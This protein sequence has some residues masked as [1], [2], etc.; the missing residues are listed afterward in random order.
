MFSETVCTFQ[1]S[2]LT[3]YSAGG[4]QFGMPFSVSN[5][6]L[7]YNKDAFTKA[8]LDPN[9]PPKTWSSMNT[10]SSTDGSKRA[11]RSEPA[12]EPLDDGAIAGYLPVSGQ[13]ITH[14]TVRE[15]RDIEEDAADYDLYP[16]VSFGVSYRF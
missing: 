5:P 12:D 15:E 7:Y 8:G 10:S 2:T 6:V 3:A 13:M 1:P 11:S 14:S 16:V 9:A 4:V